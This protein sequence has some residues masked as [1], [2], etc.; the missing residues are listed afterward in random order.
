MAAPRAAMMADPLLAV[1]ERVARPLVAAASAPNQIELRKT[2]AA[3]VG[4]VVLFLAGMH[5]L[6]TEKNA[7][8]ALMYFEQSPRTAESLRYRAQAVLELN[9]KDDAVKALHE[10]VTLDPRDA[11]SFAQLGDLH[12]EAGDF[13]S[14]VQAYRAATQAGG[15][16]TT[17]RAIFYDGKLYA[18][19]TVRSRRLTAGKPQPIPYIL[20]FDPA[21]AKVLERYRFAGVARSFTLRDNVIHIS[22]GERWE[23]DPNESAIAFSRGKFH[24]PI[25][26]GVNLLLRQQSMYSGWALAANFR[27]GDVELQPGE[28]PKFAL[29]NAPVEDDPQSLEEL[30][31]ALRAAITRDP[32]QPW[33][34]FFLGHARWANGQ[35]DEAERTWHQMLA[36][37][38]PAIAYYE[39]A[40]M[41]L[42]FERLGQPEW[43][44]RAY[45]EA[46][47]RRM[48][49]PQPILWSYLIERLI[50]IPF[51]THAASVSQ[52]GL[53]L[54]RAHLWLERARELGGISAEGEDF[55]AV[56]WEK[57]FRAR[58]ESVKAQREAE[59]LKSAQANPL[60]WVAI[61]AR[62]DYALF[63]FLAAML[64]YLLL[65]VSVLARG[66]EEGEASSVR[67]YNWREWFKTFWASR[68]VIAWPGWARSGFLALLGSLV[69][70]GVAD[71]FATGRARGWRGLVIVLLVALVTFLGR[72]LGLFRGRMASVSPRARRTVALAFLVLLVADAFVALMTQTF[73]A[74][75]SLPLGV[76]DSLGHDHFVRSMEEKLKQQD[77]EALRYATAVVN[78]MAGNRERARQLYQTLSQD[79]R[80]QKNLAALDKGELAPPVALTTEDLYRGWAALSWKEFLEYTIKPGQV[81][82]YFGVL[83]SPPHPQDYLVLLLFLFPAALLLTV[84]LFVS[85]LRISYQGP[86]A[87][88]PP[89]TRQRKWLA[90]AAY[91][92]LP[93][94]YDMRHGS[95]LLG[96]VTAVLFALPLL[97]CLVQLAMWG[98]IPAPGMISGMVPNY[99]RSFPLPTPA[100]LVDRSA[101]AAYH[102]WTFFWAFPY[103]KVFWT[104]VALAAVTSLGLHLSRLRRMWRLYE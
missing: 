26:Y 2:T 24:R 72:G 21:T 40:W 33:H 102:F 95:P 31:A 18:T 83:F 34:L 71:L 3:G 15:A 19:E 103:V 10:A 12:M 66:A 78:H 74:V 27:F 77:G 82:S 58:G 101:V 41:A 29:A 50:S 8:K 85:F 57:Y 36:G 53:N 9:R 67:V 76:M 56:A 73:I 61:S 1:Q 14:A 45:A 75:A 93:G 44:D 52:K 98:V 5:A 17:H 6:Y 100:G 70:W 88:L 16:F 69:A 87:G 60:N 97:V 99:F 48:Q 104:V 32:T 54:E 86:V 7:A 80:A 64:A 38:Y 28:E 96:Y 23:D 79:P 13:K 90:K 42:F 63:A 37:G 55:A 43:A 39:F 22:Y 11:P 47:K 94:A 92:L 46:V 20:A 81:F 91:F 84:A 51:V 49:L 62:L 30:E 65:L 25:F 35:K 4:D 59:V 68:Y 89:A